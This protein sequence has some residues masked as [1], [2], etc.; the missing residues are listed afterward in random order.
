MQFKPRGNL[1][2]YAFFCW[3]GICIFRVTLMEMPSDHNM[4]SYLIMNKLIPGKGGERDD[5]D[6]VQQ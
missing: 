4:L 6:A 2:E 1:M 3:D 5:A